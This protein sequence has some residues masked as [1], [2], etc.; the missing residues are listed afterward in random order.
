MHAVVAAGV[1]A[2]ARKVS[3]T[4]ECT[5]L[6][7]LDEV[8][9]AILEHSL[10]VEPSDASNTLALRLSVLVSILHLLLSLFHVA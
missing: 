10:I 2:W 4:V 3:L 6:R 8:I 9:L 1:C 7:L 5:E